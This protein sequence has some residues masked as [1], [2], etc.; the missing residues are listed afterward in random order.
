MTQIEALKFSRRDCMMGLAGLACAT[1]AGAAES[2]VLTAAD[3]HPKTYPTVAAVNWISERLEKET[4]GRLRIRSYFSGQLGREPDTVNLARMGGV[5]IARVNFAA[6]NNPFPLTQ[7]FSLPFVFDSVEHMRRCADG[8]V[9]RAVLNGF[10]ARDL[11]GLAIYDAGARCF[12]NVRRPVLTP[13]DLHGL[14][15]R[16]PGSDIFLDFVRALGANPTPL[17]VGDSYSALQTHLI[18]G[19]EN[20][21]QTFHSSRQFEVAKFWSQTEHSHSPEALLLSRKTFESFTPADRELVLN[22]AK[23]SVTYMRGLW[24]R[25]TIESRDTVVKAGVQVVEVDRRPF[26]AAVQPVL[27]EYL[28]HEELARLHRLVQAQA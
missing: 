26:A 25:M 2:R 14:K 20:N 13:A 6:L 15:V 10:A 24:D 22:V 9:G 19:A 17:P 18:D 28:K 8:E 12:Y 23:E 27:V 11:V 1:R 16:V 3:V 5:D 21:W 7:L 4:G